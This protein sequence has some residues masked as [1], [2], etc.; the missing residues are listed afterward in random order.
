MLK[1][2]GKLN[3][4]LLIE[5]LLIL[6]IS[7]IAFLPNLTRAG[8]YRDDWYYVLD[9][10][11]SG[12]GVFQEMFSI[13]RPARGPLF[14]AYY[15]LFEIEPL[16]YHL[17]SYV[18]RLSGGLAALYL[19]KLL[20]PNQ[21]RAAL[22]M[23]LLFTLFPGY[24]RLLEGVENQPRILSSFLQTLSI[25]LTL[26]AIKANRTIPKTLAWAGSILSGWAYIALLDF[27][28][29]M[30]FFRLLCVFL[31]V[32]HERQGLPWLNKLW[33]TLHSWALAALIPA[34]FLFW[35]LFIFQNERPTTD[36]GLQLSFLVDAPLRTGLWWLIRLFQSTVNIALLP[37]AI[38]AFQGLFGFNE[39]TIALV[40][41]TAVAAGACLLLAYRLLDK[42]APENEEPN[43][44]GIGWQVEAILIG[45][46]GIVIGV[47][48]VIMAN[49]YA[50]LGNY[51]HYALPASLASAVL[52]GGLIHA[53]SSRRVRLGVI[54]ALVMFS[55]LSHYSV[56]LQ[57]I[58]E[59]TVISNFW[60]Q[61]VWRAPGIQAG[62][63]LVVNY[64][65]VDFGQDVDTVAGPANF[66]YFPEQ[67][68][69][70]PAIYQLS[71]LEQGEYA[72][73][74]VLENPEKTY[75]FRYRTHASVVNYANL[76]VMTQP[77]E[78]SCV[79]VIDSRWP[80]QNPG[81]SYSILLVGQR[82]KVERI[83]TDAV[84]PKPAESIFGPE[85]AQRWCFYYQKAELALQNDQ[86]EQILALGEEVWAQELRPGDSIEWLPFLQAYAITGDLPHLKSVEKQARRDE[87]FRKQACQTLHTMHENG[88]PLQPQVLDEVNRL[89]CQE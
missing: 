62:T 73:K 16:P 74:D 69:Q 56:S 54:T 9:R 60:H 55:V 15:Q 17:S 12:P 36:V 29:G 32:S 63:T 47:L 14:E 72:S 57:L 81:E 6:V 45:L 28:I 41:F 37:W 19:F 65:S 4:Q 35:R 2:Q 20:W 34:V 70:I 5:I 25:A 86:W 3:Y 84:P 23:A 7:A 11:I 71:A 82:S 1:P 66:L 43:P 67:T 27:S 31:L 38:P 13:D 64:P 42:L 68:N 83:L 51:S 40:V 33:A 30:E 89:F 18:W 78:A 59:E 44:S 77:T 21:K 39:F 48:P 22:V 10:M 88:Y 8:I 87:F 85:P 79:H 58:R 75:P 80:R 46:P 61:V 49:R 50:T 76:L 53:I 24:S 26:Q 52:A